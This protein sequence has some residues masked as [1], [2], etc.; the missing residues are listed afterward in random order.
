MRDYGAVSPQFWIGKT[1][2]TLRGNVEA[3]LVALYLMTS[4]HANMIGVFYCPLDYIAK[5][6]GL[7][8]E[9]ASKGLASLI[10]G[11]FCRVDGVSEEIFVLRMAAFQIGEQLS[12]KDK[13]CI[14]VARE[15]E[16]VASAE[17][18]QGFRAIYS[19][20]FNLP[21]EAAKSAKGE[22]K[23]SPLQAPSKPRQEQ[24]QE[25][26]KKENIP[27]GFA[28]FWSCWP[29]SD[30]KGGKGKCLEA[31]KKAKAEAIA[32]QVVAHVERMKASRDWTKNGGE[33]IPGPAT[34]LNQRKWEGAR[35]EPNG[36][37]WWKAAGFPNAHEAN[38]AACYEHNAGE[39]R[40]GKRLELEL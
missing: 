40:D 4:P 27:P 29:S 6:T 17:L 5:E 35:D 31:W 25:Q 19:V 18:R 36:G 34:Y 28:L 12:P 24:E 15:L 16:K 38:N 32:D 22:P 37:I 13:R 20:A 26:D 39:F 10:E 2:K 3:Q 33:F 9:E 8:I 1:G 7:S 21:K 11:E 30:R 14:G 23:T